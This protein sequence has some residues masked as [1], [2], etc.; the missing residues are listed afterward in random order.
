[1]LRLKVT[2][3]AHRKTGSHF[4]S[5]AVRQPD[6]RFSLNPNADVVG[7]TDAIVWLACILGSRMSLT[8]RTH[9]S[10]SFGRKVIV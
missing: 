9:S 4:L 2:A 7:Q 8:H 3:C 1:M 10:L 6:G 5:E